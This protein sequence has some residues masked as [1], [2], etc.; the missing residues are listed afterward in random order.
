MKNGY[1][2]YLSRKRGNAQTWPGRKA[3][4]RRHIFEGLAVRRRA[5]SCC[6]DALNGDTRLPWEAGINSLRADEKGMILRRSPRRLVNRGECVNECEYRSRRRQ[7]ARENP[8]SPNGILQL[9]AP[10]AP[11]RSGSRL[12]DTLANLPDERNPRLKLRRLI[13]LMRRRD[14]P[15]APEMTCRR[16]STSRRGSEDSLGES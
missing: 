10:A 9:R 6:G 7:R 1:G 3:E 16:Y 5:S 4:I 11:A 13:G 14:D 2:L 12:S 15:T 8:S